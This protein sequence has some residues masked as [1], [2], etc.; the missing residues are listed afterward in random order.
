MNHIQTWQQGQFADHRKYEKMAAEWKEQ[1]AKEERHLV[2]PGPTDNPICH[3][4]DPRHAEWIAKRLNLASQL[5]KLTYDFA[6]G[7]TDGSEIVRLVRDNI[8]G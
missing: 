2:R 4:T 7:K 1:R 5:E 6:T 3:C 8:D